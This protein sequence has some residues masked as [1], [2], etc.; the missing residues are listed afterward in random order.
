MKVFANTLSKVKTELA[1][2]LTQMYPDMNEAIAYHTQEN[3]REW[4][5][6]LFDL[7]KWEATT[8]MIDID[9]I[10]YVQS[11]MEVAKTEIDDYQGI[12]DLG[13]ITV[14][15][16]ESEYHLLDGYHRILLAKDREIDTVKAVV[17]KKGQNM[18][19]NC[20]KIKQL[21]LDNL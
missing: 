16:I 4:F 6:I 20:Q 2:L 3:F 11:K 12:E 13:Y 21:I 10:Q 17:W 15:T 5:G 18:H 14:V 8:T 9:T 1:R 19:S 7:H